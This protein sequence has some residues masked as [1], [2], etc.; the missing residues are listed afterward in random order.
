[1]KRRA[2]DEVHMSCDDHLSSLIENGFVTGY[3]LVTVGGA[4]CKL[5]LVSYSIGCHFLMGSY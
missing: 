3:A 4:E 1:M 5:V 2:V